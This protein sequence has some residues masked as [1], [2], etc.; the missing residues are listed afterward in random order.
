MSGAQL[1]A[2]LNEASILAVR[3]KKM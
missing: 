1:G 2:V 3:N